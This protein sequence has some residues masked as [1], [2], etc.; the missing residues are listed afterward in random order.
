MVG[1]ILFTKATG[2]NP[3]PDGA[4]RSYEY[5][6][7]NT[8]MYPLT[9]YDVKRGDDGT[10]RIAF[11]EDKW[12]DRANA[13]DVIV[14]RG[15]EDLFGRI[16]GIVAQYKLHRLRNIY[17]PR[18]DVRDGYMWHAYIRFQKNSIS[19]SGS[20]AWPPEKLWGGIEAINAYIQSVIDAS[21]EADVIARQPYLEYK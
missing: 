17:T 19:A 13:P 12:Q 4:C 10:V 2:S 6:H 7:N 16:D 11:M 14:I 5:Q 15:P 21:T 20:N 18:A 1:G 3:R 9:F 8:S